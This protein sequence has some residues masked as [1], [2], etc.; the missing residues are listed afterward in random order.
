MFPQNCPFPLGI[1]TPTLHMVPR[2][3]PTHHP[4]RHL[5]RFSR[6]CMGR[7]CHAV[8]C[9]VSGNK[10]PKIAPRYTEIGT[11]SL[12]H[13]SRVTYLQ[14][15]NK[16]K[17]QRPHWKFCSILSRYALLTERSIGKLTIATIARISRTR[18]GSLPKLK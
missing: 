16:S 2:A 1:I 11:V 17:K 15:E 9:I 14:L 7:K 5:D 10:N 6:F 8:Q 4:K 12:T 13:R 18:C 3:K